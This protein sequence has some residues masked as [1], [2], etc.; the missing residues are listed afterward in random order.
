[1]IIA[2]TLSLL[3]LGKKNTIVALGFS[4]LRRAEAKPG[5]MKG[6]Q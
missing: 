2:L 3:K 1:M 6:I 4:S 5:H